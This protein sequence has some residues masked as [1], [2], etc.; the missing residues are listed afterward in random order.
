MLAQQSSPCRSDLLAQ[1][2]PLGFSLPQLGPVLCGLTLGPVLRR[3]TGGYGFTLGHLALSRVGL[4]DGLVLGL[5]AHGALLVVG[6]GLFV[7]AHSVL[8]QVSSAVV[9]RSSRS[10][11]D[12]RSAW[13][14]SRHERS[15]A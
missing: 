2:V 3:G 1:R 4:V 13:C 11:R 5:V 12:R 9:T 8:S 7:G 10:S 15:L 6:G 14:A